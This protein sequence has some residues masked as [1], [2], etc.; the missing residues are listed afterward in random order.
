MVSVESGR[1][2][3]AT[4]GSVRCP[5]A[6]LAKWEATMV[7]RFLNGARVAAGVVFV[8]LGA[9]QARALESCSGKYSAVLLHPLTEPT[10]VALDLHNGADVNAALAQAFTNGMREAGLVVSGTPTVKLSLSYQVIGQGAGGANGGGPN[11]GSGAQT[12]WTDWSGGGAAALEGGQTLAMPDIP[13]YDAFSPRQPVQSALLVL[14]VEARNTGGGS[15]VNWVA[16]VQ[17]TMKGTD[18]QTLAYQLGYLIGGAVGKRR[19]NDPV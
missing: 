14:R 13:S 1:R 12:G 16:S 5:E 3:V 15:T 7:L 4:A 11:Q 18:N 2:R 17:C 8:L 6:W 9:G 10:V 19:D